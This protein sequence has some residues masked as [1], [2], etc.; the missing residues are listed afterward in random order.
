MSRFDFGRVAFS[1]IMGLMVAAGCA[2]LAIIV[3]IAILWATD[4]GTWAV[5]WLF[6]LLW[7]FC[8]FAHWSSEPHPHD[9]GKS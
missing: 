4:Q 7:V 9:G 3:F 2:A 1:A 8:A 5:T 6:T